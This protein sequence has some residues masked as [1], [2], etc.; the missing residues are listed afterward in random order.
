MTVPNG[1]INMPSVDSVIQY[2]LMKLGGSLGN[3][4][5]KLEKK[6]FL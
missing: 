3:V 2:M 1:K 4:P 5:Q 6:N